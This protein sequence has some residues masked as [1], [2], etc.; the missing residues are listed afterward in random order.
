MIYKI[1][2]KKD[3]YFKISNKIISSNLSIN[4][5]EVI[6]EIEGG[7]YN[8]LKRTNYEFKVI[9]SLRSKLLRFFSRY[10]ILITGIL[11]LF[12]ILYMN[13]YRVRGIVFNRET[14]IN[15]EIEYRI[16][17]SYKRLLCFDFCSINYKE[18]SKDMQKTY[19]EYPYINVS[20]KNNLISV[21]IA[22]IDEANY[23]LSSPLEG[24]IVARKDGV[25]DIFYVYNGKS[26][27]S[28]NKYVK[29][30]DVLIEGTS[31]VRGIVLATTYD[32][33]ELSIS[34]E[35]KTEQVS[36][37]VSNYY[38]LSIFNWNVPLGKKK[39]FDLYQ[40]DEAL[41]FNL[42]D[43][44]SLKKIAETKKNVIIKTYSQDDA[45]LLAQKKIEEDF[46]EHQSSDLEHIVSM[47][48]TKVEETEDSYVFTFIVKKYESIGEFRLKE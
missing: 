20:C 4:D 16:K 45:Y 44:F 33:V 27:V 17:S 47:V 6:F 34:K 25:V 32:K 9:E 5:D 42:F 11:F 31:T 23:T 37:E 26:V 18:F 22:N 40:K 39:T 14:P 28:K 10:G 15:E 30:G 1:K 29:E 7:S 2:M 19:F 12:S 13:I 24:D 43:F 48:N 21:Y 36:D 41:V 38:D 3:D 46:K 8:I 35:F